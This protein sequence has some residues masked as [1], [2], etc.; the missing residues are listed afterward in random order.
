MDLL[1]DAPMCYSGQRD[2]ESLIRQ[3]L[4]ADEKILRFAQDDICHLSLLFFL[5]VYNLI[6]G[7]V[8]FAAA[9]GSAGIVRAAAG[10]VCRAALAGI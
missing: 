9:G 10:S 1:T 8:V 2:V 5:V 7:V 3:V 4:L 6:I